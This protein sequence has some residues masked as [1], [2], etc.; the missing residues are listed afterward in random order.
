MILINSIE[1]F[2]KKEI[3]SLCIS[4]DKKHI[5]AWSSENIIAVIKASDK[6]KNDK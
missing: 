3:N 6:N 1:V 4:Q 5:Y 2:P